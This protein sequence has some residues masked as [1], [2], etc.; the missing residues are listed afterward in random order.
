MTVMETIERK[1]VRTD[2]YT[3]ITEEQQW[4]SVGRD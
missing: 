3:S 2:E 4:C 1:K